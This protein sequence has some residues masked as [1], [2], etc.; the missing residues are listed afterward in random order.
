M[1]RRQKVMYRFQCT[2]PGR[3]WH[4]PAVGWLLGALALTVTANPTIAQERIDQERIELSGRVLSS[5]DG[6]PVS[7]AAVRV[8]GTGLAAFSDAT[9]RFRFS[10]LPPGEH[11]LVVTRL[12]FAE[13]TVQTT[14]AAG[15][16]P[17]MLEILLTPEPVLVAGI[18]VTAS[19]EF[20]RRVET[21]ASISGITGER[22]REVNPTHPFEIMNR[23][24][25]VWV[26]PTSTEGHMTSIR[27]PITTN[28]VYL[29]LEDGV[30]TRSPGFFNH[31][32]L[33]EVNVPHADRI[34][35]IRGP[36]TALYG[37]DA[38]GGV[39]DVG[40]RPPSAHPEFDGTVEVSSLGFRRALLSTATT[41]GDDGFRLDINL[42]EGDDWRDNGDYDR[43]SATLRWDRAMSDGMSLRTTATYTSVFQSDPSV[44]SWEQLREDSSLNTHPITYRSVDAFRLQSQFERRT[45]V[46]LL[47]V[48]PYV[49]W[50]SLD[51]MPSWMLGFDPVIYESGHASVGVMARYNRDLFPIPARLTAGLDVDRSPGSR[52]E[53]RIT[54]TR[55]GGIAVDWE[56]GERIYD[57]SATYLG[58]SPYI[59][60]QYQPISRL[61]LTGGLRYDR[62]TFDYVNHL[63]ALQ[64]GRHR[65]PADTTV[66]YSNLGPSLG[67]ALTLLPELNVF[68]GFRESFRS[69]SE[70]Q[71]FRQGSARS[72]V[73]LNPVRARSTEAGIRGELPGRIAYEVS[74]YRMD[75]RDDI[76][77]FVRPEDGLTESLNAGRS[78]HQGVEAG[79]TVAFPMGIQGD[80][81]MT[82]ASHR[83]IEWSPRSGVEYNGNSM[84]QAPR[85]LGSARLRSPLPL[86]NAGMIEL[87]WMRMGRFWMD[88]E[89]QNA[90]GGH[91]L[92]NLRF[93]APIHSGLALSGR[94]TNL[95]DKVFAERASFNAF[96]GAEL[97]PGKPR[98][99][100]IGLRYGWH[101]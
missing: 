93:E 91:E 4:L 15:G 5:G 44:L 101:R 17:A 36:G 20:Q 79:V 52:V 21:P 72:T 3:P 66:Q 100:Q 77:S 18:V 54:V 67:G 1:I 97:S 48:T 99:V 50:N 92:W 43:Q 30:P 90:Y 29:F 23:I 58:V 82:R 45:G 96:R 14:V 37:S 65:R 31:N 53:D 95:S 51:L 9:G 60:L 88:P 26:S 69:P 63:D 74:A 38:I 33:Y 55:E 71:L 98:T 73:D 49:R 35:V 10:D 76:L 47:H 86:L 83:F 75:V 13:A 70:G 32:A 57:Y 11:R 39:I 27:Q 56:R 42:T 19:G 59:Q 12:G 87:E 80:L 2:F 46:S 8:E 89:N 16:V 25:G 85:D 40:T 94:V 68:A 78:R 28:P 6:S 62:L 7:A 24:P 61:H 84:P 34:E 41:R 64:T 81:S 22:I